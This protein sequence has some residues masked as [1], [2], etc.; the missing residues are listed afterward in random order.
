MSHLFAVAPSEG[1]VIDVLDRVLDRGVVIEAAVRKTPGAISLTDVPVNV[2]V[3]AYEVDDRPPYD[4][5][6]RARQR[7]VRIDNPLRTERR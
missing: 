3:I 5:D 1:R 2:V 7:R 6:E 4:S